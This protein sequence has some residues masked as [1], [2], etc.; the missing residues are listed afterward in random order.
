M[1]PGI[2]AGGSGDYVPA[3]SL[4]GQVAGAAVNETATNAMTAS[5]G[6]PPYAWD[7][8]AGA[9]PEGWEIDPSTGV[10]G[11]VALFTGSYS[12]TV[13]VTDADTQTKE[14]AFTIDI[15]EVALLLHMDGSNGST[16]FTDEADSTWTRQG[17]AQ[18]STAQERF[19]GA[20]GLLDGTG[21]YVTT[22]NKTIWSLASGDF[23]IDCWVRPA[24]TKSSSPPLS[25]RT[26]G[27]NGGWQLSLTTD[28][29]IT[30]SMWQG[31]GGN[32]SHVSIVSAN[33][34]YTLN[35]WLHIA[36]VR[37]GAT[38]YLFA[39]GALLGSTSSVSGS[40]GSTTGVLQI[41]RDPIDTSRDFNG[42]IDEMRMTL[43]AARWDAPFTPPS[44][45]SDFPYSVPIGVLSKVVAWYEHD[46]VAGSAALD[47]SPN[48]LHG[49]YNGSYTLASKQIAAGFGNVVKLTA[50]TSYIEIPHDALL[51]LGSAFEV[52]VWVQ[53]DGAQANFPKLVCKP[54]NA[55]VGQGTYY[56]QHNN[57]SGG[58]MTWRSTIGA[59]NRDAV[60]STTM[61]DLTTYA[62][63][64]KRN[65]ASGS[66]IY[67][68]NTSE[69]TNTNVGTVVTGTNAVRQGQ[70]DVSDGFI[71]WIG[72]TILFKKELTAAERAYLYNAGAGRSYATVLADAT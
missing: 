65:S 5:G 56:V 20:S 30:W 11:G 64:G 53:R 15:G 63:N 55:P 8:S 24:A 72:A 46:E 2:T 18:I 69:G 67:I 16:T 35:T 10:V 27:Q 60:S 6:T 66:V 39:N 40:I 41:G 43:G 54:T 33:D 51:N 21:D 28:N 47:S 58:T 50:N 49:T 62:I 29:R 23:T 59:T 26:N 45:P 22:P 32:P 1:I 42:Y 17:N 13:R 36:V 25:K 48:A 3:L 70:S 38:Y 7:I 37:K 61:A 44:A 4:S 14:L 19:G 34:A 12:F 9:L 71:G 52:M 68:N 31:V 57:F